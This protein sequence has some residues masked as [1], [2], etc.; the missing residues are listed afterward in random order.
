ML[1]KPKILVVDDVRANLVAMRKLL[2]RLNCDAIEA[3]SGNE[4]LALCIDHDFA[5]ILL[6]VDMP[7]MDGYEVARFLKDEPSTRHIPI[8][9]VTAT[10][11]DQEHQLRGYE[12]GAVDYIHKPVDDI[13]LL[14]KAGIFLDLYNN[15]QIAMRELARSEAMRLASMESE[16]RFRLA[17]TDAPIPIMLHA[18][19]GEV[20]LL[21]HMWTELTG[22]ARRDIATIKDWLVRAFG[23]QTLE[24][25]EREI[26]RQFAEDD[27]NPLDEQKLR[28]ANGNHLFWDFRSGSLAT[29]PDGRR[30]AITMAVDVTERK[31]VEEEMRLAS[32]VFQSSSEGMTITDAD[33]TIISVNPA[34]TSLTGYSP[35]EVIGKKPNILKSGRHDIAFYQAMWR[36][37]N[38]TGHWGG[39][40]WNQRKNGEVYAERLLINTIYNDDGVAHR[41]VA[42]FS[43][44]T[45]KKK[46]EELIWQQAHFDPLTGLPNR[47]MFHDRLQQ[48][49]NKADRTGL[50]FA[51]IFLDLDRFKEV[52]DT[53]GHNMGDELLKQVSQRLSCCVRNYDTVARL[54][55]DE[56]TIILSNLEEL[57]GVERVARAILHNLSEAFLLGDEVFQSSAS[58]GITLY[59][60]DADTLEALIKSA[61]Q[62]MYVA[63]QQ[64]RNRYHYFTPSLQENAQ[65]RMRLINDLRG[66]LADNQFRLYYQPII[67]LATGGIRKAE[68]L[69]RWQHPT[70]GLIDPYEFIRVAEETGMI[71]EIGDWVCR[72]AARQVG[73]WR[74]ALSIE[75]Q[76]SINKSPMQFNDAEDAQ[77]EWLDQVRALGLP[78]QSLGVEI[79]E[80]LLM[81]A[82]TDVIDKLLELRNAGIQVS[83]DD[84]GTGY[85]SLAYLKKFHIDYLKIDQSFVRNL[86]PDSDDMALCEAI[87]VMAHKLGLKVIAEGVETEDQRKLLIDIG[88][89]YGQG[90]L[91]SK[92]IPSEE[93]ELL[94]TSGLNHRQRG[95]RE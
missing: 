8:I 48:E 37:L 88:C 38:S 2:N 86:A 4:A 78:T 36:D 23:E 34:F 51:L 13:I 61:D 52:N 6:D 40:I 87:T 32:L 45:Q 55:G 41:R 95:A 71:V 85:C 21:N 31:R 59:P 63:K 20:V 93:F 53:F 46:D 70:R 49:I 9:F 64:G 75:F 30:L 42:L 44:I 83:L 68:A 92:P 39:E 28:A 26:E 47:R 72:E 57:N 25:R 74:S 54:G 90:Y 15:R 56:F 80:G 58:I 3:A 24:E 22:Y 62:A 16:K 17:L 11:E 94:L 67:E 43:D 1:E 35:D 81:D 69:I 60:K 18:D 65:V 19:D 89:D 27:W 29:L 7:G 5:V 50:P 66:A 33:A 77:T 12:A 73:H 79:T 14:S 91:F 82:G 84:F 10:Y 76:I